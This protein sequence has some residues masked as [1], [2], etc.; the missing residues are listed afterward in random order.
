[1]VR[2]GSLAPS[3]GAWLAASNYVGLFVALPD[4]EPALSGMVYAGVGL[5]IAFAGLFCLAAARTSAASSRPALR[6]R[7][8]FSYAGG[9]HDQVDVVGTFVC[10]RSQG[11]LE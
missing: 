4:R 2:D 8:R 9:Q 6:D 10:M 7:P 5:G 3:A 1:M 11:M